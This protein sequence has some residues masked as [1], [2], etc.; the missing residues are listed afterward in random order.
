MGVTQPNLSPSVGRERHR[1]LNSVLRS[2][3][4]RR[5][6][7][8]IAALLLVLCSLPIAAQPTD[9]PSPAPASTP[10][11]PQPPMGHPQPPAPP[12]LTLREAIDQAL[13]GNPSLRIAAL[14][15]EAARHNAA[16]AGADALPQIKVSVMA[17]E[18]LEPIKFFFEGG[19]LGTFPGIGPVP[20][21][22]TAV[23]AKP[24]ITTFID[25]SVEQA[26][27]QLPR[28][29]WNQQVQEANAAIAR[30]TLRQEQQQIVAQVKQAYYGAVAAIAALEAGESAMVYDLEVE[31]TTTAYVQQQAQ[32]LSY[33]IS[34][35][36]QVLQQGQ[37]NL[38]LQHNVANYKEQLNLLMGRPLE[39]P[40][41]LQRLEPETPAP[42]VL[43]QLQALALAQR[44]EVRQAD[45]KV[46]QGELGVR[47]QESQFWPDLGLQLRYLKPYGSGL[48]PTPIYTAGAV[49][50]WQPYDW[51]E[52][53]HQLAA[54]RSQLAQAQEQA[55]YTREQV[56]LNVNQAFRSLQEAQA[57]VEV[58][59]T[60]RDS[61]REQ[62]RVAVE[63]YKVKDIMLQDLLQAQ[64]AMATA[65]AQVQQA[66]MQWASARASLAQAV[67]EE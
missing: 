1:G 23:I 28:I 15:V 25:A 9:A 14:Q 6:V 10:G 3:Y 38:T 21:S 67:G 8:L 50:Q 42:D 54:Q 11:E 20:A 34:A 37:S 56:T 27:T 48:F 36:T 43:P 58:A 19:S 44:P 2:T 49:L 39:T 13:A 53:E 18:Q 33:Q 62:L 63:R 17:S 7:F 41:D 47:I 57:G 24:G 4:T 31:R 40:F 5:P 16:A 45:L 32:L 22:R 30:E 61:A 59:R 64:S 60:N 29:R 51:G 52:R 65:E 55:K 66:L 46:R 12:Q 35:R 26:V